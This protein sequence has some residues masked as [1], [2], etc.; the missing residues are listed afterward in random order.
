MVIAIT[1]E[2]THFDDINEV[3]SLLT[4]IQAFITSN[5][6]VEVHVVLGGS[7]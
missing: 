3:K 4:T 6:G 5:P 2:I 7:L 1:I